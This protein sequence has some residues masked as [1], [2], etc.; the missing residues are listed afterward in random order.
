[1]EERKKALLPQR[2]V[3]LLWGQTTRKAGQ[4]DG[5]SCPL[6]ALVLP[7]VLTAVFRT[8]LGC[9]IHLPECK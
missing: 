9:T 5:V 3:W 6:K 2:P 1:M 4:L 7:A 8:F